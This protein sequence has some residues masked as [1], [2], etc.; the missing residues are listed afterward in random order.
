MFSS[1]SSA[2]WPPPSTGHPSRCPPTPAPA[3]CWRG[4]RSTRARTRAQRLAGLLRPDV[5]EESARKTLRDAVY[6]LRRAFAP[7]EPVVATRES[8]ELRAEVDLAAFAAHA[9][10]GAAAKRPRGSRAGCASGAA[11]TR[12]AASGAARRRDAACGAA[13]ARVMGC[14]GSARVTRHSARAARRAGL[15]L[16]AAGARRARGG[17]RAPCSRRWPSGAEGAEAIAWT[18]AR[19]EHEPL[20][21]AAH[22]DL[23]RLLATAGDR[24]AALA[25]ADQLAERLR[26]ELRVPPSAGDARAGRGGAARTRRRD[27]AR[28]AAPAARAARADRPPRGPRAAAGAPEGGV[29]RR[30]DRHAADRGRDRRARDRQDDPARRVRAARAREGAAVLFGRSDEQ[31]LLPYQPWVEALER[32]LDGCR[33]SSASALGDGALARLLPSLAQRRAE[34]R[35]RRRA[36]PRVRGRPRA[37]RGDRRRAPGAARARRPALGRPGLAAAAPPPRADGARRAA[38]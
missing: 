31:G 17:R 16:G 4:S 10:G 30:R 9:R 37:A 12:R 13:R 32:H 34:R 5:A 26:R 8:V 11:A 23:I 19:V 28:D 22:R 36:L 21:E 1:A 7:A 20:G 24:P 29:G 27:R 2:A 25:V 35:S 33:R 6:E 14:S 38:C 15:R 3:S 18:R